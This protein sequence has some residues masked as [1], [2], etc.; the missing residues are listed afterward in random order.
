MKTDFNKLPLTLRYGIYAGAGAILFFVG[1]K[2]YKDISTKIKLKK[3]AKEQEESIVKVTIINQ[4]NGTGVTTNLNLS[5]I[6]GN[7]YDAFYNNDF[8]NWT[9]DETRAVTEIKK[10]PKQYISQLA[11]IYS[12]TYQKNLQN[13]FTEFC[14][15]DEL[16]KIDYLFN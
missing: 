14:D 13:D 1:R 8:F 7:I 6:A 3:I 11:Q 4:E 5:L 10:V 12:D 2:V 15:S 9:E 16:D